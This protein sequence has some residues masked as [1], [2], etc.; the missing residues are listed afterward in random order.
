MKKSFWVILG[1]LLIAIIFAA[2][3]FCRHKTATVTIG[4]KRYSVELALTDSERQKG[5][6]NRTSL[7]IDKGM[8][9]VFP[10]ANIWSFWMKDTLIPLDIIWLNDNI[11]VEMTTLSKET[12]DNIPRY[13]PK[14]K[15]NRVLELNAGEISE[16]N[17][18]IG[19]KV[20]IQFE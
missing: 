13:T 14:N 4:N 9:F 8:L 1:L 5:L 2:I 11:I 7:G 17:F 6:S 12:S 15:A 18:Q 16:N 3:Y 20:A 19:D 10:D